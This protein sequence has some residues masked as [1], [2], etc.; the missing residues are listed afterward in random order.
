MPARLLSQLAIPQFSCALKG[1]LSEALELLCNVIIRS[2]PFRPFTIRKAAQFFCA[3]NDK[4]VK[5]DMTD[6][7][8]WAARPGRAVARFTTE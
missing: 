4:I 3:L 6:M 7:L 2:G 1:L 8:R 5:I